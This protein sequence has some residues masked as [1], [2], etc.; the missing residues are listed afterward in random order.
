[1]ISLKTTQ[2][3]FTLVFSSEFNKRPKFAGFEFDAE[4]RIAVTD[5]L[6]GHVIARRGYGPNM[7]FFLAVFVVPG[8]MLDGAATA[9]VDLLQE[10]TRYAFALLAH[11]HWQ[12]RP[13]LP[14]VRRPK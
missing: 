6:E 9:M 5:D 3:A 1:V 13:R 2:Q 12:F 7:D 11:N 10:Q 14:R 8:R 4:L